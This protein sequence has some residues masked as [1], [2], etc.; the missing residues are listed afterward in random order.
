MSTNQKVHYYRNKTNHCY[1]GR[2]AHVPKWVKETCCPSIAPGGTWL[3]LGPHDEEPSDNGVMTLLLAN[4]NHFTVCCIGTEKQV[5]EELDALNVTPLD[6]RHF[7]ASGKSPDGKEDWIARVFVGAHRILD[8]VTH[9]KKEAIALGG[10]I[11][12][13][14]NVIR[15]QEQNMAAEREIAALRAKLA[16]IEEKSAA[17]THR[18]RKGQVVV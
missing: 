14:N 6:D 10:T 2:P 3:G 17:D 12:A 18:A 4:G 11:T 5:S 15:L 7:K 1:I 8:E 13:T 16:S 9:E